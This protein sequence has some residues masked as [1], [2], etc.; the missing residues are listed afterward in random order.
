MSSEI[1]VAKKMNNIL[2]TNYTNKMYFEEARLANPNRTPS[3][4]RMFDDNYLLYTNDEAK[5]KRQKRL[6]INNEYIKTRSGFYLSY[7]RTI[8]T[9]SGVGTR[10][11]ICTIQI[12]NQ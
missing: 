12:L 10:K 9:N 4:K 7:C 8:T 3:R 2:K 5:L 1:G 6:P 11:L